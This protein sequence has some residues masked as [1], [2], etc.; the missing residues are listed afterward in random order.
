MA[1]ATQKRVKSWLPVIREVRQ[2][3]GLSEQQYADEVLLALIDVESDGQARAHRSGSQFYTILQIGT[4]SGAEFGL[5]PSTL[6]NV[7]ARASGTA[8]IRHFFRVME[9]YTKRHE[10]EPSRMAII[11]KGG[12]GTAK[13]YGKLRDEKGATQ[14]QLTAFLRSRWRT[15]KYVAR[16]EHDWKYWSAQGESV[17]LT[18]LTY[19][20]G[21]SSG[22]TVATP[23]RTPDGK[24]IFSTAVSTLSG[25]GGSNAV[26]QV[27]VSAPLPEARTK[28]VST[29]NLARARKSKTSALEYIERAYLQ[30]LAVYKEGSFVRYRAKNGFTERGYKRVSA[31]VDDAVS[32]AFEQSFRAIF[33]DA[34]T[35]WVRPLVNPVVG[36]SPWGKKR[37]FPAKARNVGEKRSILRDPETGEKLYRRH[38]GVDYATTR[39]GRGK[40]QA[41]HAVA[42]GKVLR[43]SSSK[44]YG[45]VIYLD[46]GDGVTTRYAHLRRFKVKTGDTVRAG[47][48]IGITGQ[49]EGTANPGGRGFTIDHNKLSPHLHFEL[50]INTGVMRGGSVAGGLFSNVTNIS[51]D[52]EPLF[53]VCPNPG[54][55]REDVSPTLAKALEA[56]DAAADYVA[57][58]SSAEGR[59]QALIAYDAVTARLRAEQLACASRKQFYDAEVSAQG[60][61]S[62]VSA[63]RLN[64]LPSTLDPDEVA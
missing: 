22:L 41:C 29:V 44:S 59:I 15:D 61:V 48:L 18:A 53:S 54:E 9:K 39:N 11:W 64:I 28:S 24:L 26:T 58:S 62:T 8:A 13:T 45:L 40:N 57:V 30:D 12:V 47:D 52:P 14:A 42:D 38:F 3:M 60:V 51:L 37:S 17:P 33:E 32:G 36:N 43:A 5:V 21:T 55:V 56:R 19:E 49:S 6:D 46:H 2:S 31:F 20:P 25:C 34:I 27:S 23:S 16:F 10:Y 4:N 35:S 63:Q 1:T 7:S 50:R